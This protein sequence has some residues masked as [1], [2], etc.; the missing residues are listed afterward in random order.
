MKILSGE[1]FAARFD[2]VRPLHP[3]PVEQLGG[4]PFEYGA[5]EKGTR[6]SLPKARQI[7]AELRAEVL[8]VEKRELYD[9]F[10]AEEK[11]VES[12][13]EQLRK[14]NDERFAA[15]QE[16]DSLKRKHRARARSK[17]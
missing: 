5:C 15:L 10:K 6:I 11:R 13:G 2:F 17:G 9:A 3:A 4:V 1:E 7:I 14:A 16:L 8:E 12:Y